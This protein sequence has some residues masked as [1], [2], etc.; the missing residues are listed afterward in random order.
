MNSVD[1]NLIIGAGSR[2]QRGAA[3]PPG[4]ALAL[5][6]DL[7][8]PSPENCILSQT[9]QSEVGEDLFNF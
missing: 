5:L 1:S 8:P 9:T 4:N 6:G 3:A 7:R 2:G